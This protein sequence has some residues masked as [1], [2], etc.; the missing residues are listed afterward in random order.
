MQVWIIIIKLMI[1]MAIQFCK[2][3]MVRRIIRVLISFRQECEL[4]GNVY[5]VLIFHTYH[6]HDNKKED[7]HDRTGE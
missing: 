1:S 6:S 5:N 3:Q 4:K 7:Q 2:M